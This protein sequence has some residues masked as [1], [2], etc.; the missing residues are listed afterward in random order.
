MYASVI[1]QVPVKEVKK[2]LIT[3][4]TTG[5]QR[6]LANY[7]FTFSAEGMYTSNNSDVIYLHPSRLSSQYNYPPYL[8]ALAYEVK[9]GKDIVF[10]TTRIKADLQFRTIRKEWE[11]SNNYYAS[12]Y[13]GIN[14][15]AERF[16]YKQMEKY[17]KKYNGEFGLTDDGYSI[18][19]RNISCGNETEGIVKYK[20]ITLFFKRDRTDTQRAIFEFSTWMYDTA[21]RCDL[22]GSL[23]P[24]LSSSGQMCWGNRNEDIDNYIRNNSIPFIVDLVKES[25][26]S[27]SPDRPYIS[28]KKLIVQIELMNRIWKGQ[29]KA[30]SSALFRSGLDTIPK[31][32]H[33]YQFFF[34]NQCVN[35]NCEANPNAEIACPSCSSRTEVGLYNPTTSSYDWICCNEN[36]NENPN[37]AMN[38]AIKI[39]ALAALLPETFDATSCRICNR[40]LLRFGSTGYCEQHHTVGT[41]LTWNAAQTIHGIAIPNLLFAEIL[42]RGHYTPENNYIHAN[43]IPVR[44]DLVVNC[45]TCGAVMDKTEDDRYTCMV[46][47]CSDRDYYIIYQDEIQCRDDGDCPNC[48]RELEYERL[49]DSY[50]CLHCEDS[51]SPYE[52]Q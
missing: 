43:L 1:C 21:W 5:E 49:N 10:V 37:Y 33:C 12:R 34:D 52:I 40:T 46:D 42:A 22:I 47:G 6:Y 32:P 39:D 9:Y 31:C 14:L 41:I 17:V 3:P 45:P 4:M 7:G 48:G 26:F 30:D 51:Y 44:P 20:K 11:D 13:R 16:D 27:Y 50:F 28:I 36:C 25:L 35:A 23:H 24:H 29:K 18:A 15:S 2:V 38:L 19:F 8:I